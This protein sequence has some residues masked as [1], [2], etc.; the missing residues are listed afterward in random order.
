MKIK[1]KS[2]NYKPIARDEMID[3]FFANP[4]LLGCIAVGDWVSFTWSSRAL[5]SL[6]LVVGTILLV[7]RTSAQKIL[8]IASHAEN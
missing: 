8:I 2:P 6:V 5:Y 7:R 1:E 4:I 3:I